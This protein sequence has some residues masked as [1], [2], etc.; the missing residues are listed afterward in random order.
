MPIIPS[1]L[2]SGHHFSWGIHPRCAMEVNVPTY[3]PSPWSCWPNMVAAL[4][5]LMLN[6]TH[7]IFLS[8]V[9]QAIKAPCHCQQTDP[10]QRPQGRTLPT[11]WAPPALASFFLVEKPCS[12]FCL[13]QKATSEPCKSWACSTWRRAGWGEGALSAAWWEGGTEMEPGSSWRFTVMKGNRQKLQCRRF[14]VGIWEKNCSQK[15][16][17]S[18]PKSL[19]NLLNWRYLNL[20]WVM[21]W[22]AWFNSQF[23]PEIF[24]VGPAP[25]R[26]LG[27][28]QR[29]LPTNYSTIIFFFCCDCSFW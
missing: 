23:G 26:G 22:A 29:S 8:N 27:K 16:G 3:V 4:P 21:F 20:D 24:K 25:S 12:Q 13:T 1:V 14:P 7:Y 5:K 17:A 9:Y 6:L 11:L 19:K 18:C 28:L 2:G 10:V 15:N